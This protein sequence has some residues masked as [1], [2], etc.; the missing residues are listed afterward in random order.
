MLHLLKINFLQNDLL[1]LVSNHSRRRL[2]D[3]LVIHN[4][5]RNADLLISSSWPSDGIHGDGAMELDSDFFKDSLPRTAVS[6]ILLRGPP[7]AIYITNLSF[8][9]QTWSR[10]LLC[11]FYLS[12]SQ[13]V[14]LLS[15]DDILRILLAEIVCCI[16]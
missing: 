4:D 9:P 12:N 2:F 3:V 15:V 11:I 1:L 13:G 8:R 10:N 6:Q 7:G 5:A 14:S 16:V